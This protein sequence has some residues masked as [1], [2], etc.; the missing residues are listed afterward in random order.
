MALLVVRDGGLATSGPAEGPAGAGVLGLVGLYKIWNCRGDLAI[1]TG[2]TASTLTSRV[3][4][5]GFVSCSGVPACP[6]QDDEGGA[7]VVDLE[8]CEWPDNGS[9]WGARLA[10]DC[11]SCVSG[12]SLC[13]EA[14]TTN[15]LSR[16]GGGA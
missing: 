9:S 2:V 5:A 16:R 13:K 3:P 8:A 15:S 10:G 12:T 11:G 6:G 4:A 1:G 7:G 14:P